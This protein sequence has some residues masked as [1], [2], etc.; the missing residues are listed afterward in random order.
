MRFTFACY[1]Q[2]S[3]DKAF[4]GA[5]AE[6][7]Q[8]PYA[9]NLSRLTCTLRAEFARIELDGATDDDEPRCRMIA[10]TYAEKLLPISGAHLIAGFPNWREFGRIQVVRVEDAPN[11]SWVHGM[12]GANPAILCPECNQPMV[13]RRGSPPFW[14]CESYPQ[15]RGTRTM[16][17]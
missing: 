5:A 7:S 12:E 6:M 9:R 1:L 8:Y 11:P 2:L 17:A 14:G 4:P 15:C 10:E 13:M 16:S 3:A